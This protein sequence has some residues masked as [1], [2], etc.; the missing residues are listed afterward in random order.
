MNK[1]GR[2]RR[3]KKEKKRKEEMESSHKDYTVLGFSL[4][5]SLVWPGIS[6]K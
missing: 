4:S 1:R 3:K 5:I 6:G 2:R